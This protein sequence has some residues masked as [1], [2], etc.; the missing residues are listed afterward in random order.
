[1]LACKTLQVYISTMKYKKDV[2][3]TIFEVLI[4]DI[5]EEQEQKVIEVTR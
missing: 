2:S 1:M 5:I 3:F 4:M